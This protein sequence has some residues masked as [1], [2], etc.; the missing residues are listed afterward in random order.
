MRLP[1]QTR[2]LIDRASTTLDKTVTEF[3]LESARLRAIDVLLD[4]RLLQLDEAA[5]EAFAAALD[6]PPLPVPELRRLF[7]SSAPWE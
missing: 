3:L 2:Q 4:Q 5:S 1:A 7:K 6:N